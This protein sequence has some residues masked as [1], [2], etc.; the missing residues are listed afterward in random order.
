MSYCHNIRSGFAKSKCI[1]YFFDL[2]LGIIPDS[3][4]ISAEALTFF[5]PIS[6]FYLI[7]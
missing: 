2:R 1:F 4:S 5:K 6:F 7:G 3:P